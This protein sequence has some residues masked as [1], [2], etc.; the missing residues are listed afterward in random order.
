MKVINYYNQNYLNASDVITLVEPLIE[1]KE[2]MAAFKSFIKYEEVVLETEATRYKGLEKIGSYKILPIEIT[3]D[4]SIPLFKE[5]LNCTC[6]SVSTHESEDDTYVFRHKN[7]SEDLLT[8]IVDERSEA[9]LV[10][11]RLKYLIIKLEEIY[12]SVEDV[13]LAP[14]DI[15]MSGSLVK[16]TLKNVYDTKCPEI[17][18]S[19]L[20]NPKKAIPVVLKRLNKVFRENLE[21]LRDFKKFWR[22]IAEEHYY[23]AYDT[24]GVLYRS[25]EKNYLSLRNVECESHSPLSFDVKDFELLSNIRNFF[26]V[27][28]KSHA[29]NSFRKPAVEAQLQVFDSLLEEL[30]KESTSK[31]TN[32]NTYAL[33]YYL[34]M[35]YTRLEEIKK[36]KL[37][38]ISSNPVTVSISLQEEYHIEDRYAEILKAAEELMNK[39]LDADRFEEI[40]RRMT[41]SMGYKLYNFKKIVSK[42]ERQVNS[43]IEGNTEEVQDEEGEQ[44]NY[45]IVKAG[46]IVTIRRVEDSAIEEVSTNKN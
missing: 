6:V 43:L 18:E 25:Q 23:K 42:I 45:S 7:H 29:S 27:F 33:Y 26:S 31:I 10:M 4:S 20:I 14:N 2:N 21:R 15:Q 12:E 22:D 13:E 36:L 44:A 32:F 19:I 5:V 40:V 38:P 16:E 30:Y 1:D 35:L 11:D 28:A 41:D 17:L 24:K 39:Q 3:L 8:R 37:E 46:S 34:L 9:D